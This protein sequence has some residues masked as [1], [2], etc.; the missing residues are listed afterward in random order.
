M[1]VFVMRLFLCLLSYTRC[2]GFCPA[3]MWCLNKTTKKLIFCFWKHEW[4]TFIVTIS[5]PILMLVREEGC[6]RNFEEIFWFTLRGNSQLAVWA[7]TVTLAV[8]RQGIH[9]C[10]EAT[11]CSAFKIFIFIEL[12]FTFD[13]LVKSI[14]GY[15]SFGFTLLSHAVKMIKLVLD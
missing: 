6:F 15:H 5:F 14:F 11:I 12:C 3:S 10:K 9:T 1:S 8:L 4:F 2:L 7:F 13:L